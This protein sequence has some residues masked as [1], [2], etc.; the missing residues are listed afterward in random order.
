MRARVL[1]PFVV[2]G[3]VVVLVAGALAATSHTVRIQ[4]PNDVRG[5][6][7]VREVRLRYD[8]GPATWSVITYQPWIA[9]Q[10]WDRGHFF[11]FLDTL[12][13]ERPEYYAV[14]HSMRT[15]LVAELRRFYDDLILMRLPVS[16]TARTSVS[17]RVPLFKLKFGSARTSYH[18]SAMTSFVGPVCQMTCFDLVPNSGEPSPEQWRPGMSPTAAGP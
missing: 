4:D 6:L 17:V 8:P 10:I 7:D 5:K 14:I 15:R 13:D 12:G 3:V 9:R 16:R 18:W 11:I 1:F 2:A